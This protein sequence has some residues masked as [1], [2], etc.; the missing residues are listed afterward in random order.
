MEIS[1]HYVSFAEYLEHWFYHLNYG[2]MD[3]KNGKRS[4]VL[5]IYFPYRGLRCTFLDGSTK[6]NQNSP[7]NFSNS[8]VCMHSRTKDL[9]R[10]H[11]NISFVE[12][13]KNTSNADEHCHIYD[14]IVKDKNMYLFWK[15]ISVVL[16]YRQ[17]TILFKW[18]KQKTATHKMSTNMLTLPLVSIYCTLA[19]F[20]KFMLENLRLKWIY[21]IKRIIN[22]EF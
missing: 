9:W 22:I 10:K 7:I 15:Q 16:H 8:N 3:Q 6:A 21:S 1:L 5:K 20:L 17:I 2:R 11:L 14:K 4:S 13:S 19:S 12:S 18:S